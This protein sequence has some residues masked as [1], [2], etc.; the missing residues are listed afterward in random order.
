[1]TTNGVLFNAE[2]AHRLLQAGLDRITLSLDG[3]TGACVALMAGLRVG[4]ATEE[5]I[6]MKVL[7]A[8]DHAI[9]AGFNL[10]VWSLKLNAVITRSG[11][12]I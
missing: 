10:A 12:A 6:L 3:T 4:E 2:W 8:I 9:A 1:M 7:A 5:I 11:N